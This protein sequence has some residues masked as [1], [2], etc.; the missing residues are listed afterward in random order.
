[1]LKVTALV[2]TLFLVFI[3]GYLVWALP[4]GLLVTSAAKQ[5]DISVKLD[6]VTRVATVAWVAVGWIALE[7][8]LSWGRA[9]L[10]ARA[11]RRTAAPAAPPAPHAP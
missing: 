9:W 10:A 7:T 2:R 11:Q 1:M 8:A 4:L 6:L 5:G 3:V